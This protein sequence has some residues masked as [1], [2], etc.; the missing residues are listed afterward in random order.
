MND[1][2]ISYSSRNLTEA[3]ALRSVLTD[4]GISVWMAPDS[5][6]AGMRYMQAIVDGIDGCAAMVVV[7]SEDAQ[8]SE[9]VEREVNF[10]ISYHPKKLLCALIVDGNPLKGWMRLVLQNRQI[11][12]AAQICAGDR[13]TDRLLASLKKLC[14]AA[15][16][17]SVP[18]SADG[19]DF[20]IADGVLKRYT[21]SGGSVWIPAG[22]TA[23]GQ[24]A[25]L[26]RSDMTSVQF[27]FSLTQIGQS[28]FRGC[29]GLTE[30]QLPRNLI[31]LSADA[32]CQCTALRRVQFVRTPAAIG[33]GAF[34]ECTQL[35]DVLFPMAF[36]ITC[37]TGGVD[38]GSGVFQHTPFA[39]Q[40]HKYMRYF[41]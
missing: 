41:K 14:G 13:G 21:G 34:A 25:F 35:T 4:A 38:I 31:V 9:Q 22:V 3:E 37:D 1:V 8:A 17:A 12:T 26:G 10:M 7:V 29:T 15:P 19:A 39:A 40:D 2:F 20:E 18:F 5:I 30:I 11:E 24:G 36:M 28:A 33:G 32:F 23:I 16:A 6:P 27:P